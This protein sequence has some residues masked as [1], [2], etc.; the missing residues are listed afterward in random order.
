MYAKGKAGQNHPLKQAGAQNMAS[1]YS[2]CLSNALEDTFSCS[3]PI[4]DQPASASYNCSAEPEPSHYG[5]CFASE[6][7]IFLQSFKKDRKPKTTRNSRRQ[8]PRHR[9][10]ILQT[11]ARYSPRSTSPQAPLAG[12][13]S[14]TEGPRA[15]VQGIR[16]G[17]PQSTP[18]NQP[19]DTARDGVLRPKLAT[20]VAFQ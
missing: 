3:A 20:A 4:L 7:R 19:G 18:A 17:A 9:T 13:G 8:S 5:C 14:S 11:F 1:L 2:A 10:T 6:E 15:H 16:W 12:G